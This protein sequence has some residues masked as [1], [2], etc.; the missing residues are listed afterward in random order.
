M[1]PNRIAWLSRSDPPDAFPDVAYA[2]AEPDGLLAAGGDLSS[3]RLLSA[4]R[5]GI[6]PWYDSGQPVLWWS[7]DPRCVMR[8]A[9]LHVSRRLRQQLRNSHAE[10]RF[11]TAFSRVI[12]ACAGK[13]RSQQGTW[14]TG[15]M[16]AAYERLYAE[17]WAHSIEV[18]DDGD[19][20]GGIYGLCIGRVFF[21]ESM[22]S[23]RPNA[24]KFAL[25]GLTRHMLVSG[26]ELIDCQ[27]VSQHLLTL[28]A[29]TIPRREFTAILERACDPAERHETWPQ[30]PVPVRGLRPRM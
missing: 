23:A 5:R 15:D 8:P 26:L 18:W 10:L 21:G 13:R 11:N 19:L 12:R 17:R 22:Y 28:G 1:S 6:F 9:E 4:Y 7:P 25:L 3:E 2:L 24:S 27:V 14:I 29:Q 30:D 16:V 20:I